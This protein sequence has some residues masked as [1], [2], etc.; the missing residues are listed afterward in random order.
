MT[1]KMLR[2]ELDRAEDAEQQSDEQLRLLVTLID[3]ANGPNATVNAIDCARTVAAAL[4]LNERLR[5]S[6]EKLRR[7]S[8]A[9]RP[10]T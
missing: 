4:T 5:D 1:P 8:R 10:A 7:M 6:A 3:K 2:T 9:V